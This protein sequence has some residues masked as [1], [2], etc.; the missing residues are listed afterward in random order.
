MTAASPKVA[1]I[2]TRIWSSHVSAGQQ[3]VI[4]TAAH[5][6]II[7]DVELIASY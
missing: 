2:L 6:A 3:G 1:I 4:R 5:A 7:A